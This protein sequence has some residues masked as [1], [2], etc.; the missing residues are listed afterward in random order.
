MA[1]TGCTLSYLGV[2]EFPNTTSLSFADLN[3]MFRSSTG[4]GSLFVLVLVCFCRQLA[5][6]TNSG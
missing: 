3:N 6:M 2:T 4:V 1:S 5:S